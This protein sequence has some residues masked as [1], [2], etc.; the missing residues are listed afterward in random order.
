MS[1]RIDKLC[2][3]LK[4]RLD[5]IDDGVQRAKASI[6]AAPAKAG[7]AIQAK[8]DQILRL[9]FAYAIEGDSQCFVHLSMGKFISCR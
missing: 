1:E 6:S 4:T 2:D 9:L 8:L 7:Q 3:E 5:A